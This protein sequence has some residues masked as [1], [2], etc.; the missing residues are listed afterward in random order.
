LPVLVVRYPKEKW[1]KVNIS[2]FLSQFKNIE[3]SSLVEVPEADLRRVLE[4]LERKWATNWRNFFT[5]L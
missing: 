2:R 1:R 4:V 5:T 3:A